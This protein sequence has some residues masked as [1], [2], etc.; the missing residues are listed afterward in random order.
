MF[1][2]K[3]AFAA[4]QGSPGGMN[5]A[6]TH[7]CQV[8]RHPY[9]VATTFPA[10]RR[11]RIFPAREP[12]SRLRPPGRSPLL[13]SNYLYKIATPPG[14]DRITRRAA[15]RPI[16]P[17]ARPKGVAACGADLAPKPAGAAAADAAR[18]DLQTANLQRAAVRS[19]RSIL[20]RCPKAPP[21][22]KKPRPKAKSTPT[23]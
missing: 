22:S 16:F 21:W 23:P 18:D 7:N 14:A 4:R 2:S 11:G 3:R 12:V 15:G 17:K 19:R 10:I 8:R 20:T 13:F 1:L 9:G 6:P 5:P